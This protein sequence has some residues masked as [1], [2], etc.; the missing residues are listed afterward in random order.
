MTQ[1]IRILLVASIVM[2]STSLKFS[3]SDWKELDLG[4]YYHSFSASVNSDIGDSKI[5]VLKIDPSMYALNL[6]CAGQKKESS[7]PIKEW[8]QK[9]NAIAGINAGMFKLEGDH[10]ICTGFMK[11][12]T[13]INNGQL[14]PAYRSVFACNAKDGTV[15]AAQIIDLSCQNWEVLKS[16]YN[17]FSQ[18]IRMM[19]CNKKNTWQKQ[20]K[21]WSMVTVGEDESGNILFIFVRSPYR[22]YDYINLLQQLPLKLK[23]LMYLEGGPEASFYIN[24]P[25]LKIEKEGS[26]ETGFNENDNN[27]VFWDIPNILMVTK[28]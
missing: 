10:N 5:D 1:M 2:L 15:P 14:N 8:C 26:Y 11:N 13:Y 18:G 20:E 27:K 16:K 21:K 3:E 6:V 28:K 22:V 24:H 25:K 12:Y 23:R 7:K 17:T 9:Y 19:D 4:L